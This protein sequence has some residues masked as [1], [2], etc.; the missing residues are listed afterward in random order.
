MSTAVIS[1][2][3]NVGASA[4]KVNSDTFSDLA[5]RYS[6]RGRLV[7]ALLA[8]KPSARESCLSDALQVIADLEV[9]SVHGTGYTPPT[10]AGFGSDNAAVIAQ[11]ILGVRKSKGQIAGL[12]ARLGKG[13]AN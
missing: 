3:R 6:Q 11:A 10:D 13:S 1:D 4:G 7:G 9:M 8:M 12:F 5:R 2:N